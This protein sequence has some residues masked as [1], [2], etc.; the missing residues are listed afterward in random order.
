MKWLSVEERGGRTLQIDSLDDRK[1]L[2]TAIGSLLDKQY[3]SC[4]YNRGQ[5]I[6]KGGRYV[7]HVPVAADLGVR[8][9]PKTPIARLLQFLSI[10]DARLETIT[11]SLVDVEY[12]NLDT[13]ILDL[14]RRSFAKELRVLSVKGILRDYREREE[15]S[16]DYRGLLDIEQTLTRVWPVG[17]YSRVAFKFHTLASDIALNR[18]IKYAIWYLSNTRR[19]NLAQDDAA[20]L[21]W[22]YS[23]F[24]SVSL[25]SSLLFR[26]ELHRFLARPAHAE[27]YTSFLPL[28]RM[29]D[30][31]IRRITA[32]IEVAPGF[33]QVLPP[34]VV[35]LEKAFER[36]VFRL[37]EDGPLRDD[38]LSQDDVNFFE[39]SE[40]S[41]TPL[42]KP[43]DTWDRDLSLYV[44][45]TATAHPDFIARSGGEVKLVADT[46]YKLNGSASDIHQCAAHADAFNCRNVLLIYPDQTSSE[47]GFQFLGVLGMKRVY[48]CMVPLN[49]LDLS[50]IGRDLQSCVLQVV[51]APVGDA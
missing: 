43:P 19:E 7:G 10:S 34:M 18:A 28:L 26:D 22:A 39:T 51:A 36:F 42:L 49:S 29:A 38:E 50:Q 14:M 2:T 41:D 21:N 1:K 12:W 8:I 48:R 27:P 5:L 44:K 47:I 17:D 31:I 20:T 16:S 40:Y 4:E 37:L 24:S 45:G 9:T 11:E 32:S 25:D 15:A 35:D 13:D 3:Y 23:Y 46:K 6:L 30:V 33:R